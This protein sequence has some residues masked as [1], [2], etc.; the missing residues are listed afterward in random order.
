MLIYV[1]W[2]RPS[3]ISD[4]HKK[5]KSVEDLSL[6]ILGQF[7]FIYPSGF[8]EE[9][10]WNTFPTGSNVKLSPAEAAIFQFISEQK[11]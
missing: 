5:G 4:R 8:R 7:G 10:F 9:A 3:W 6:I 11:T 2:W 1:L